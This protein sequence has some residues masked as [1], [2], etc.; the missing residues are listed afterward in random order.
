MIRIWGIKTVIKRRLH[1]KI[2]PVLLRQEMVMAFEHVTC[3]RGPG[4]FLTRNLDTLYETLWHKL[5]GQDT[6]NN[7]RNTLIE[8]LLILINPY[9]TCRRPVSPR[10]RG[11]PSCHS[12]YSSTSG[13]IREETESLRTVR[14]PSRTPGTWPPCPC[15]GSSPASGQTCPCSSVGAPTAAPEQSSCH[16]L[17]S[18]A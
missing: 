1:F 12:G 16:K 4:A 10:Q 6:V 17:I 9:L 2:S 3:A 18:S 7:T 15:G 13:D 5:V 11:R 8:S 14:S